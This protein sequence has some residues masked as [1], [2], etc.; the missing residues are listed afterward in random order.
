MK[1]IMDMP[2]HSVGFF[3]IIPFLLMLAGCV[4]TDVGNPPDKPTIQAALQFEFD[5]G[6]S[7][8]FEFDRAWLSFKRIRMIERD[9]CTDEAAVDVPNAAPFEMLAWRRPSQ[10]LVITQRAEEFCR[11]G[12]IF[13]PIAALTLPSGAPVEAVG[14]SL[15]ITGVIPE[16]QGQRV[17]ITL[18][19]TQK[20]KL[21]SLVQDSFKLEQRERIHELLV[22]INTSEWGSAE[23]LRAAD[24]KADGNVLISATSNRAI[25]DDIM[26]S[27]ES[28][29]SIFYDQDNDGEFSEAERIDPV[30][31]GG[32][33]AP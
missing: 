12:M 19:L 9:D 1:S 29:V 15:V 2:R 11:V 13:E 6:D 28:Q 24:K 21:D 26:I 5:A 31:A 7:P 16:A 3:P 30:A 25:Y 8:A 33:V 17:T 14:S 32:I 10:P 22:S 4:V 27:L 20:L 23:A 18:D